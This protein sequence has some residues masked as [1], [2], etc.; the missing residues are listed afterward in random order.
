MLHQQTFLISASWTMQV[1]LQWQPPICI[2]SSAS[3]LG[4]TAAAQGAQALQ[5][6]PGLISKTPLH[7][8]PP[9]ASAGRPAPRSA[10]GPTAGQQPGP[11]AA[12]PASVH[13][14]SPARCGSRRGAGRQPAHLPAG[15]VPLPAQLRAWQP[16]PGQP[17]PAALQP[18]LSRQGASPSPRTERA[19]RCTI[20][21]SSDTIS[22]TVE[23]CQLS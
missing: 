4:W 11:L 12:G 9:P 22:S 6:G 13:A 14:A 7:V 17:R 21:G 1:S 2:C 23:C 15:S 8:R 10:P 20:S 19:S 5:A 16:G 3:P 18:P